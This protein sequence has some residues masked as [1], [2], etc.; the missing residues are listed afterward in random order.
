MPDIIESAPTGRAGCRGCTLKIA[1]GEARFGKRFDNPYGEGEA[2]HWYHL[3]CGAEAE[4]DRVEA[5][6]ADA[7]VPLP[8]GL[9]DWLDAGRKNSGL[10]QTYFAE[11]A[12]SGR[13]RC[14]HCRKKID[15]GA[16]RV[17]IAPGGEG[18]S[19]IRKAFLHLD[20]APDFAGTYG[21]TERLVRTSVALPESDRNAIRD[22]LSKRIDSAQEGWQPGE[23]AVGSKPIRPPVKT[24]G[25]DVLRP[26][27][28]TKDSKGPDHEAGRTP[29]PDPDAEEETNTAP[30]L[31]TR[32]Q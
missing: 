3:A 6:L 19:V 25:G 10:A 24:S 23:E 12:T 4:P 11:R 1:K 15:N 30:E 27:A 9:D 8:S 22:A 26:V 28:K 7:D 18:P 31:R 20:C 14:Q 13:A 17:V 5:A 29:H 16:L 21:L 2:T 32:R